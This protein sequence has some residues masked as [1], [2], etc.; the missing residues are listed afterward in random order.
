MS[1]TKSGS[2]L[3]E[4]STQLAGAVDRAAESIVAIHAR[5]RIASSGIVWRDGVIVSASHT[6]KRDGDVTVTLP[7]GQP[8]T[9]TVVGRDPA[10]DLV[11][12]RL[13][14]AKGVAAPRAEAGADR[15][16]SLVL[17]IGRP[18]RNASASFGIVSSVLDGWRTAYG[19]RIDR[20]LRLD[21]A[22]Y[23]GF[24]GGAL[25]DPSGRVIGINTSALARGTPVSL[26]AATVDAVLDDLLGRGH[27]RRP[28]I[29]IA[30][31]P[32]ALGAAVRARHQLDREIA[33]VVVSV[34]DGAPADVGG[35]SVGDVVIEVNGT[36]LRSP[37]DLLDVISS[38]REGA[39]VELRLLRGDALRNVRLT[40]IDADAAGATK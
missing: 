28:F 8:A 2:A 7:D 23:D 29:G 36:A 4:L 21:L 26:S 32:V 40:P 12:L 1:V 38:A 31:H 15:V 9:A 6:V 17:A 11:A 16:G 34:A 33:F 30:V 25:V 19:K 27:V 13:A 22:V 37:S 20:V 14:G 10:T 24:S 5:K 18:G 3:A 39:A 35:V